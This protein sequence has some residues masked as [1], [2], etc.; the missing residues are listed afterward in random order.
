M[1]VYRQT[2]NTYVIEQNGLPYEVIQDEN[3]EL[4][5][6]LENERLAN[7][8][9]FEIDLQEELPSV[10][11]PITEEQQRLLDLE[12]AMAAILGGGL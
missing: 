8:D 6:E 2:R 7:S 4:H 12:V 11:M 9:D 10:E 5:L 3:A 1:K